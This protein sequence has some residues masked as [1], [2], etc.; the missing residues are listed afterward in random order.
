MDPYVASRSVRT[1]CISKAEAVN[2]IFR[3]P[4]LNNTFV[5][6]D[7]PALIYHTVNPNVV[8]KVTNELHLQQIQEKIELKAAQWRSL[9]IIPPWES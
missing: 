5:M 8:T 1:A 9:G 7:N 2:L 6:A 3:V 4:I